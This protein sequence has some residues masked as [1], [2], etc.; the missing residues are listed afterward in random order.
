[1]LFGKKITCKSANV[2]QLC[3]KMQ[4]S[5]KMENTIFTCTCPR[6]LRVLKSAVRGEPLAWFFGQKWV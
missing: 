3:E 2:L 5:E 6:D 4:N 1:M